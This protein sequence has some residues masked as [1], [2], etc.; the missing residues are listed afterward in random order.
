MARFAAIALLVT[1]CYGCGDDAS[2][3]DA[4]PPDP[5][6]AEAAQFY[7]LRVGARW[8]YLRSGD[9]MRWKEITGC[10]DVLVL[11]PSTG[12]PSLVRAY[13]RENRSIFGT[14]S[15]H[16]LVVDDTGV[17]RVRRD[18]VD[19]GN[20]VVFTTYDPASP[21]LLNGPYHA[22]DQRT[23]SIRTAEF[24]AFD[25]SP[26]GFSD[27]SAVDDVL[28]SQDLTVVAG[29]FRALGMVR[30]WAAFNAH[31]V[32]SDFVGG[33]G[34][35]LE[36]TVWPSIPLPTTQIEEL[37]AYTPGYASC[38]GPALV[39][40]ACPVDRDVCDDAWGS[41]A[42]GC[43]D[44]R[45]D[46]SNCG[47]CDLPCASGVCAGGV[48][49][50][51]AC[52]VPCEG[53][54]VCCPAAWHWG[55]AGCTSPSR[56]RWNCGGCGIACQPSEICDRGKCACAPGTADCIGQGGCQD[57]LR[58]ANNCGACGNVCGG[59]TPICDKGICVESC[60]S[61]DLTEC[62]SNQCVDL[63]WNSNH[64][65]ACGHSCGAGTGSLACAAGKC[66]P[67]AAA[68]LTDCANN[69]VDLAWSDKNC[70]MCGHACAS[71]QVCVF[72]GCIGGD[73]TCATACARGGDICCRGECVNP[74]TSDHHCGG[75]G[76]AQCTGGCTEACRNGRCT[77]VDCGGGDD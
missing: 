42:R 76:V 31:R 58:D 46:P 69:C 45:V 1:G 71:D 47:A 68:G 56:D 3:R 64:C 28:G 18:D 33:V 73:G 44:V 55:V 7:G 39:A 53:A 5:V 21:R 67:C 30:Q 19:E 35:V 66:V 72:G 63:N 13:V 37:V 25:D 41:G 32:R 4:A 2:V 17:R 48:C 65:G 50:V 20:L 75:C 38:G 24:N 77:R 27:T 34:E 70:G 54:T 11:D 26:R 14:T 10:E 23:F 51:D 57:V 29:Q 6:I 36:E 60:V 61:V 74:R 52:T 22:G 15:V 16:Y 40:V 62:G 8:T 49:Q 9:V 59:G 12:Q 43:T